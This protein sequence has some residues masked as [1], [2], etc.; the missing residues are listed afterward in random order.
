MMGPQ[1]MKPLSLVHCDIGMTD[2]PV[3]I[4]TLMEVRWTEKQKFQPES[5]LSGL[6]FLLNSP[7]IDAEAFSKHD[8]LTE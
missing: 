2:A 3:S 6:Q 5:Y 7:G 4:P 8:K 1:P